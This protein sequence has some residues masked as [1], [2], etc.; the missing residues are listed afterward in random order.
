MKVILKIWIFLALLFY[1]VNLQAQLR[2]GIRTGINFANALVGNLPP[3]IKTV[4]KPSFLASGVVEYSLN[5]NFALETGLILSGKGTKVVNS[6]VSGGSTTTTYSLL[7]LDIPINAMYKIGTGKTKLV[8]LAGAYI[9]YGISGKVKTSGLTT[10]SRDIKYGN[11]AEDDLKGTDFGIN[12]GAGLEIYNFQIRGLCSVGLTNLNPDNSS[13]LV[14]RSNII[15]I[16]VG[17][18]F[19]KSLK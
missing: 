17:Y 14:I 3:G 16:S 18:L 11:T 5:K 19:G 4:I 1:S 9:A 12:F 15:G 7:S 13:T 10:E 8:L 6:N 2:Y